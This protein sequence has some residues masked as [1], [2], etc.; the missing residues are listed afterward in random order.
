[1][2]D[3]DHSAEKQS[4]SGPLHDLHRRQILGLNRRMGL[5]DIDEVG[6]QEQA[7]LKFMALRSTETMDGLRK[8]TLYLTGKYVQLLCK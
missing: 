4:P 7:Q 1:M 8:E 3:V 6:I 5:E 2:M